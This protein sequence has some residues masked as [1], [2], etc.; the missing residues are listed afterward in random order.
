MKATTLPG[1]RMPGF[2]GIAFRARTDASH[3]K[4][5]SDYGA[6]QGSMELHRAGNELQGRWSGAFGQDQPI[7][8]T[9]ETA[10]SSLHLVE[11]GRVKSRRPWLRSWPG[12]LM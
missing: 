3:T 6:Y 12:G 2:I 11:R 10:M 9:G 7:S 5:T 4:F 1:V 8:G